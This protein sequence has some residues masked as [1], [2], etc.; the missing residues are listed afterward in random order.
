MLITFECSKC[1]THL[2]I[3]AASVGKQVV[4]PRCQAAQE[5]PKQGVGPGTTVGGFKIERLLGKGGMGEVYLARQVSLDRGVALKILPA[6]MSAD[7]ANAANFLQE[8]RLLARL[9]HPNIVTAYEAGEDCGVLFLAMAFIRGE[10]L[11]VRLRTAGAL[12]EKEAL[13]ITLKLAMALSYAWTQHQLLHQDLKPGNILLD[14][15]G[16]PKLVDLGVTPHYMSPEQLAG[17]GKIDFRSD[18]FSLGATLYHMVTGKV[19]FEGR[20]VSPLPN[21]A[22]VAPLPD[23]RAVN[24]ALSENLALLLGHMLARQPQCRY[25][26]W[27]AL[28]ADI[29]NVIAGKPPAKASLPPGESLV[30][31]KASGRAPK[32]VK[33]GPGADAAAPRSRPATRVQPAAREPSN[34][35]LPIVLV[36]VGILVLTAIFLL[37]ASQSARQREELEAARAAAAAAAAATAPQGTRTAPAAGPGSGE[38]SP[39]SSF[40]KPSA[41]GAGGAKTPQQRGTDRVIEKL[42]SAAEKKLAEGDPKGALDLIENYTGPYVVETASMRADMAQALRGKAG[43]DT[44][45]SEAERAESAKAAFRKLADDVAAALLGGDFAAATNRLQAA[46]GDPALSPVSGSVVAARDLVGVAGAFPERILASFER[47]R[48]REVELILKDGRTGRFVI[49]GR[50]GDGIR[51]QRIG[52]G[53]AVEMTLSLADMGVK[54]EIRRLGDD[55]TPEF[56]VM[57]GLV[58]AGHENWTAAGQY[59]AEAKDPIAAALRRAVTGRA[60]DSQEAAEREALARILETAGA[61]A[62]LSQPTNIVASISGRSFPSNRVAQIQAAAAQFQKQ[63]GQTKT[64][65]EFG[66]VIDAL[67]TVSAAEP[68]ASAPNRPRLKEASKAAMDKALVELHKGNPGV[69]WLEKSCEVKEGAIILSLAGN[70]DLK[71]IAALAGQPITDLDLTDTAVRDLGPLADVA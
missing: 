24:P 29:R 62:D 23:P 45:P 5:V 51:A 26:S 54:E 20:A 53:R 39:L 14:A 57:R 38:P 13:S 25:E 37:F 12:A 31:V 2:E 30:A 4:C 33:V 60:G 46:S 7:K 6:E 67:L 28:V 8:M 70:P 61:P 49:L 48:S 40:H 1:Q 55:Q 3:D 50:E 36:V 42:R 56:A 18:M 16:E 41:P 59:F 17:T 11:E 64:G 63:Y 68:S 47:D 71:D 9:E 65:T 27:D 15:S 44:G 52:P 22:P 69:R 35:A 21:A 19:P 34:S 66:G 10:S 32:R 43:V 58:A